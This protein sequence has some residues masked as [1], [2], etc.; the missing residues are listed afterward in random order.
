MPDIGGEQINRP[1]PQAADSDRAEGLELVV[2]DDGASTRV[3]A[4]GELDMGTAPG[5]AEVL[6]GLLDAGVRQIELDLSRLTFVSAAG[7]GVFC[8]ATA[9]SRQAG[10]RLRLTG[11]TPR[12]RRILRITGLDGVLDMQP[13]GTQ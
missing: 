7:L 9:R 12:T 4:V 8:T 11:V 1:P 10:G 5:L 2:A 13:P 6:D 3:L